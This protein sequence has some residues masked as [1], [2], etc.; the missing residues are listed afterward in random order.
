MLLVGVCGGVP[1]CAD[2]FKHVR[3]GDIIVSAPRDYAGKGGKKT[4]GESVDEAS[5]NKLDNSFY[6]YCDKVTTICDDSNSKNN[7]NSN[8]NINNNNGTSSADTSPSKQSLSGL[9]NRRFSVKGWSPVDHSLL[10]LAW[11]VASGGSND[12]VASYKEHSSWHKYLQEGQQQLEGQEVKF[13]R[14]P[15]ETD[16]L[17][18]RLGGAD[19]IEVAYY[20]CNY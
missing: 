12:L 2:Y 13:S 11:Q 8:N 14:P 9:E 7:G 20:I 17:F 19:V 4:Q 5:N 15:P 1:Q 10:Q 18:M 3:L 16:R 6:L